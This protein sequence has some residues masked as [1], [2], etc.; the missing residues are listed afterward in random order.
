MEEVTVKIQQVNYTQSRF[1]LIMKQ[2][3]YYQKHI[4]TLNGLLFVHV[5]TNKHQIHA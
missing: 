3:V 1:P 2:A 4:F 5:K